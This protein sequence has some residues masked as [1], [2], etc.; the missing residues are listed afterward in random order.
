MPG[1]NLADLDSIPTYKKEAVDS[2]RPL[3]WLVHPAIYPLWMDFIVDVH[4]VPV[5]YDAPQNN[6]HQR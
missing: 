3:F 1:A 2:R 5:G 4:E 6:I